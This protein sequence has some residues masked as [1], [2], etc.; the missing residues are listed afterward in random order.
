[1]LAST[2]GNKKIDKLFSKH[3]SFYNKSIESLS[4]YFDFNVAMYPININSTIIDIRNN[5]NY[6]VNNNNNDNNYQQLNVLYIGSIPLFM[7]LLFLIICRSMH[8]SCSN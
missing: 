7:I 5:A 3:S 8:K 2:N 1:M 4:E 6:A